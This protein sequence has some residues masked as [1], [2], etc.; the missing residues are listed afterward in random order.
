MNGHIPTGFTQGVE[1][2][3]RAL[4]SLPDAA[5]HQVRA[6]LDALSQHRMQHGDDPTEAP[7]S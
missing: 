4:D 5:L 3:K 1:E 6:H 2:I 7:E